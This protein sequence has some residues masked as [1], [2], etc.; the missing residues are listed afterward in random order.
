MGARGG[1]AGSDDVGEWAENG[2]IV[3][4][5]SDMKT[6]GSATFRNVYYCVG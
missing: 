2:G 4:I 5:A 3:G 1:F 6:F